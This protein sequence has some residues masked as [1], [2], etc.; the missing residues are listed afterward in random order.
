MLNS[1]TVSYTK[2]AFALLIP[3]F[4]V[5]C[6][7][8]DE[9]D[10]RDI[11]D[12]QVVNFSKKGITVNGKIKIMNPNS[13]GFKIVNSEFDL[14]INNRKIGKAHIDN[15]IK[16]SGNSNEYHSVTLKTDLSSLDIGAMAGFLALAI[17]PPDKIDYKVE[18]F[19]VGKV[20]LFRKKIEIDQGGVV[21]IQFN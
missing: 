1:H 8:Y 5:S 18:G 12:I 6:F 21:P 10:I 9:V 3:L 2:I 7:N 17:A 16:V 14:T 19:V 13:Y 15:K 11:K 20:F 4:C